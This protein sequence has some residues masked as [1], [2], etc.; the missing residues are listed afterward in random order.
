LSLGFGDKFGFILICHVPLK[1][2][3]EE[4]LQQFGFDFAQ[5][6]SKGSGLLFGK[7]RYAINRPLIY[8]FDERAA[9]SFCVIVLSM[10][11]LDVSPAEPY[12]APP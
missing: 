2:G 1:F 5:R 8:F 3:I 4:Q 10:G 6:F 11:S 7:S 9:F 12:D